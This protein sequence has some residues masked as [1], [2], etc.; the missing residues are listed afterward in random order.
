MC[1]ILGQFRAHG[2]CILIR[3]S[4]RCNGNDSSPVLRSRPTTSIH[5]IINQP[6]VC[7]CE[8]HWTWSKGHKSHEVRLY[9][10]FANIA[11]FHPNWSNGTAAV[12]GDKI[13]NDGI[14]YWEVKVSQRLFGTSMM[15]GIGT[16]NTR[17]HVDAFVNLLGEDQWSMGLSH[18]GL[19]WYNGTWKQYT[20]PFRENEATT[21]GLLFNGPKGTLTYYKDGE[22]LGVAFEGL[23]RIE[24]NLYP[25][26][27]STAAKTEMTLTNCRRCFTSLQDR[28]RHVILKHIDSPL[29]LRTLP[30]SYNTKEF[31]YEK[32]T[33]P[34]FWMSDK[35]YSL[36]PWRQKLFSRHFVRILNLLFIREYVHFIFLFY[37]LLWFVSFDLLRGHPVS[38]NDL[39]L[40]L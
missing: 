11:H 28:C 7:E 6:S 38:I 2:W 19:A 1:C 9:G 31:L 39:Y 22:C 34:R 36:A 18:K 29:S 27:A 23:H 13:L 3:R 17:L 25:I 33:V 21:I 40:R 8:D 30:I 20:K 4:F 26:I 35:K 16:A 32:A 15:F 24:Q 12:R 5:Q 37:V 14:Y 10:E